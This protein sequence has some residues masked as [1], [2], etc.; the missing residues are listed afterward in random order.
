V[1]SFRC[2]LWRSFLELLLYLLVYVSSGLFPCLIWSD[3]ICVECS[4]FWETDSGSLLLSDPRGSTRY[5]DTTISPETNSLVTT[6]N[7]LHYITYA[8]GYESEL[9]IIWPRHRLSHVDSDKENGMLTSPATVLCISLM[10][11]SVHSPVI[12]DITTQWT[13]SLRN[14]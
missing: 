5:P 8:A 10:C 14:F 1:H 12:L 7:T 2:L 11:L 3:L 6:P 9:L 4:S 13:C